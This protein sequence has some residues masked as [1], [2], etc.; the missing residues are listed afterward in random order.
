MH[1]VYFVKLNKDDANDA[2]GAIERVES[3]LESN[4]F[5]L[6][7]GYWGGGKCDWFVVGG[8]WSGVLSGLGIKGDFD[9]EARKLVQA[10]EP[11]EKGHDF[12]SDQMAEKYADQIQRL[13]LKMGGKNENPYA[14]DTY[15][16]DGYDDDA[17][18]L[19]SAVIAALK[20]KWPEGVEYFDSDAF[21][22]RNLSEL[23]ADD[24]GHWLVMI[25]YHN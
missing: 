3:M 2:R 8:R 18:V 19:N 21:E 13:W 9:D 1:Y 4:G 23:S 17:V 7:E 6:N 20:E 24:I 11:G 22:E 5:V 25:D 14:R 12:L 10:S 16:T 15:K